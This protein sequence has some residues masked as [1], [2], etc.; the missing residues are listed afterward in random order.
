MTNHV[1]LRQSVTLIRVIFVAALLVSVSF[2]AGAEEFTNAIHAFLQHCI[3]TERVNAG[4]VIGI[5]DQQGRSIVSCG[6]LDNGTDQEVDGDTVFEIGSITKTF[7]TLL[8]QDMV[9]RGGMKLDDPVARYLPASVS[10]PFRNG[11]EI[12]LL[13]LA[14]H[15][16]GLPREP[17][18][19]EISVPDNPCADYTVEKLYAFLSGYKLSRDPGV[20]FEYSNPGIAVLAQAIALKAG[21]DYESLVVNRIC[22]PLK[23]DGTRI[24]L[25]P[26][27][28]ARLAVGHS[29]LGSTVPSSDFG[30]F[31]PV[32]ELRST[33]NDML[34]YLS[35]G[36]GLTS[37]SVTATLQKAQEVRV[38]D[39]MPD[40][41]IG[42]AWL[43]S[44]DPEGRI[45]PGITAP[46]M[47]FLRMLALTK[48]SAAAWWS[49]PVRG[50]SMTF[51]TREGFCSHANGSQIAVRRRPSSTTAGSMILLWG[52]TSVHPICR[53]DCSR[54]GNFSSTR[55]KQSFAPPQF[56]VSPCG[57][58]L[59]GRRA[60]PENVGFSRL[61]EP[62]PWF[63]LPLFLSLR[64]DHQRANFTNS[65]SV[66]AGKESIS[67]PRSWVPGRGPLMYCY[68]RSLRNC[69]R[70]R[71]AVF[72]TG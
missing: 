60:V 9:E 72:L 7:T 61:A 18:N 67:L 65:A 13:Q 62:L 24:T 26:D 31:A 16:S 4:I 69:C 53:P 35:A 15:M 32:G 37:S 54:Y 23:M 22:R 25:T 29:P 19:Y 52:N 42:L 21:A 12:S 6:R 70:N 58:F 5:V 50:G 59:S 1:K 49:C 30:A 63:F 36:L 33:A 17:D 45:S 46:P 44:R 71:R 39:V 38:S 34:N 64:R 2:S 27:L 41:D 47:A 3:E 20:K 14:T 11:K 66:F 68:A 8:L 48:R 43:T 51:S 56:S 55:T 57:G 28:K 10:M 40:A